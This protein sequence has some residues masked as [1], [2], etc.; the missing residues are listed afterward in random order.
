MSRLFITRFLN[1]YMLVASLFLLPACN[2]GKIYHCYKHIQQSEWEKSDTMVFA[3]PAIQGSGHYKL[4]AGLRINHT[5]PFMGL[6]L[7]I[8]QEVFSSTGHNK[9]PQIVTSHSDT[10]ACNLITQKGNTLGKGI[11]YLQYDIPVKQ[12]QLNQGDSLVVKIRHDMKRETLPGISDI[13]FVM[14]S[15]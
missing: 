6:T 14:T 4:G 9:H 5:Y 15:L 10:I 1:S 8:D 11:S 7:I 3:V 2:D 12:L 13:G